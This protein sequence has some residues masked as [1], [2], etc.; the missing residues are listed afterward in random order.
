MPARV[1]PQAQPPSTQ[2]NIP[3][4]LEALLLP[5]ESQSTTPAGVLVSGL[6]L[7]DLPAPKITP[8]RAFP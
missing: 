4:T 8:A 2:T 5:N 1:L 3:A 7:S 6:L